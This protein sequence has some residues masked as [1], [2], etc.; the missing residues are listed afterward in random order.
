MGAALLVAGSILRA[1]ARHMRWPDAQMGYL[2]A[3]SPFGSCARP[4]SRPHT[5]LHAESEYTLNGRPIEGPLR[6]VGGVLLVR[7]KEPIE[8][9]EGGLLI[10]TESQEKQTIGQVV[11]SGP[12]ALHP[13][14]GVRLPTDVT[15][16]DWVLFGQYDGQNIDYNGSDHVLIDSD[17]IVAKLSGEGAETGRPTPTNIAPLRDCLLVKLLEP[18]TKSAGGVILSPMGTK[19]SEPINGKV[20]SVGE[21]GYDMNGKRLPIDVTSGDNIRFSEFASEDKNIQ[22]GDDKYVFIKISD[23]MAKW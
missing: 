18:E 1:D 7:R 4:S 5:R 15:E 14:T 11:A 10:P 17:N 6:P 19:E 12:G 20:I 3:P 9:T 22:F 13:Q 8:K 23:V 16:G 2:V 21:G